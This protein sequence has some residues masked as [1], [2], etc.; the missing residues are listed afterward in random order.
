MDVW[1][2]RSIHDLLH[3]YNHN[4]MYSLVKSHYADATESVDNR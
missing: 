2:H 1:I 4:M 3:Q